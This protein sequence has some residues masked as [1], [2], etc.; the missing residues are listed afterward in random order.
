MLLGREMAATG[1]AMP[2]VMMVKLVQMVSL[3][4]AAAAAKRLTWR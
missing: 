2:A 3:V 1:C 4:A